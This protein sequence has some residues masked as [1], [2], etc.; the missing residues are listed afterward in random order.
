MHCY[1][2]AEYNKERSISSVNHFHKRVYANLMSGYEKIV[3]KLVSMLS[4]LDHIKLQVKIFK[5]LLMLK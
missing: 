3:T 4:N 2:V 1:I 5:K